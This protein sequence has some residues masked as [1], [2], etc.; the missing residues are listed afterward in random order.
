MTPYFKHQLRNFILL[1]PIFYGAIGLFLMCLNAFG[2]GQEYGDTLSFYWAG[3]LSLLMLLKIC[4]IFAL[5]YLTAS[6]ARH[7]SEP[8]IGRR[9]WR[10]SV[11]TL[12]ATTCTAVGVTF[13]NHD[14]VQKGVNNS[15]YRR[16]SPDDFQE[17]MYA[18]LTKVGDGPDFYPNFLNPNILVTELLAVVFVVIASFATMWLFRREPQRA[19]V[20][21]PIICIACL[22]VY[23]TVFAPWSYIPDFDFFVGDMVL[24]AMTGELSVFI[25]PFDGVAAAVIGANTAAS[26]LLFHYWQKN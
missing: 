10:Q 18:G 3:G 15:A 8:E 6:F 1:S 17:I 20:F 12:I 16:M 26:L 7:F 25:F 2:I 24:G 19:A 23:G 9:R 21:A 11:V 14:F 13:L 22:V 4:T 5:F